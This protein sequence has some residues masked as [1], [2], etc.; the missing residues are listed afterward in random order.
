MILKPT[1]LDRSNKLNN[2]F[3]I[4][5][6]KYKNFLKI[7]H[8]H[9]ELELVVLVKSTGTRFVGNHIDKFKEGEIVLLGKNL[10]HMWINDSA[11]FKKDSNLV[12]EAIVI[13][14]KEDFAGEDFIDLPELTIISELFDCAKIGIKFSGAKQDE[15]IK[16][17]TALIQMDGFDRLMSFLIILK[18][19]AADFE[20]E[21]LSS[22]SFIHEFK[23]VDKKKLEPIYK[24]I[25]EN[26]RNNFT[27]ED[28]AKVAHMNPAAF[29][30]YFQKVHKKTLTRYV[31]ELKV[32]YACKLIRE[33]KHS[34]ASICFKSGFNNVSNFNRQFKN[35]LTYSP[36]E[37]NKKY[38]NIL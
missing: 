20:R 17:I 14:F 26:Y 13:H 12:A 35:I 15:M 2:S 9:K 3:S 21:L 36:S 32:G 1:L 23:K 7:W 5:H 30:R 25:V 34:M 27:L 6:K 28:I 29:S 4:K 31:N 33:N 24:F 37:Y 19:L 18:D 10:P 38:R 16:R 8:Y 22:T 11:Y